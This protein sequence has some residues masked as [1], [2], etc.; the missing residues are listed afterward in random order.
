MLEKRTLIDIWLCSYS[1][2]H[3]AVL[4]KLCPDLDSRGKPNLNRIDPVNIWMG[5]LQEI[6][7][8]ECRGRQ[9]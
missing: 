9:C 8:S 3:Y 7:R 2:I 1:C 6:P 5:Y 4:K